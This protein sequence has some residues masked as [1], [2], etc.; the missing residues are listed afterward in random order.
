MRNN[1]IPFLFPIWC[2]GQNIDNE[3]KV[4]APIEAITV[5]LVGAEITQAKTVAVDAGRTLI[6]FTG[7]SSH[8]ISKSI[9][10]AVGSE[11]SILSI[12]SKINYLEEKSVTEKVRHLQDSL[13]HLNALISQIAYERE[14]YLVEKELLKNNSSMGGKEKAVSLTELKAAADFYRTRIKEINI[15][16]FRLD[17]ATEGFKKVLDKVTNALGIFSG[18][19]NQGVA[20]VSILLS[21]PAKADP[22]IELKYLV[23][24]AGWAPSY[25]LI[26]E[27]ATKPIELKYKAKVFNN[28]NVDWNNV[29]LKLSTSDPSLNASKPNLNT[30]YLNFE[31]ELGNYAYN[32]EERKVQKTANGFYMDGQAAQELN[33]V[34]MQSVTKEG[35]LYGDN[36]WA[37]KTK[38]SKADLSRVSYEE[39]QVSE[40][41]V[42]FDIKNTY[43]IP[44][45]AQPY[46]VEVTNYTLP[47]TFK[48]Y[49]T[50]KVEKNAFLLARIAGWEQLDLVEGPANIYFGGTF[51]GHSYIYTRSLDDTLDLSFGRDKKVMVSRTRIKEFNAKSFSGT[52][53]K[54]TQSFE[55]VVKNTRKNP[56]TI[57][58]EDQLPISQN[59]EIIVDAIEISKAKKDEATGKL[60][61]NYTIAPG[62]QQKIILTYSIRYPK[63]KQVKSKRYRSI[64]APK[65]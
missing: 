40:L 15:E 34:Q 33:Q 49:C 57:D 30:W 17:K 65:F 47:A 37:E 2:L 55:I 12:S 23:A 6:T 51:V 38:P 22:R 1:L 64:S 27:D 41:S 20:E 5:Y 52:N 14:S 63:T 50:P 28:T 3:K 24:D 35:R 29:K 42:E 53:K 48:H 44:A 19:E 60:I 10:V 54:E 31:N 32:N 16:L 26:A 11:I 43:S 9:Q 8:L 56:I 21:S 61:W 58:I 46:L 18:Q 36:N 7:I 13:D 39:V 62:E 45:D 25:D 59:S 4:Q